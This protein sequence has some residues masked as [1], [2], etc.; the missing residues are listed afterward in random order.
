MMIKLTMEERI[1]QKAGTKGCYPTL[2]IVLIVLNYKTKF[3]NVEKYLSEE[4]MNICNLILEFGR[5][6]FKGRFFR[7]NIKIS[8][9]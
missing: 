6:S 7:L 1:S 5:S 8:S 2:N 9:I 3:D 4:S